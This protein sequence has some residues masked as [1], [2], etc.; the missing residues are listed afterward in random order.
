MVTA[1]TFAAEFA[2]IYTA[3]HIAAALID[4]ALR[5]AR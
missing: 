4:V 3:L 5:R 1:L 2:V